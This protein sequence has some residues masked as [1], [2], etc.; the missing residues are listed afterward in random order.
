MKIE[1]LPRKDSK[2]DTS[3]IGGKIKQA[4][5][6]CGLSQIELAREIGLKSATAISLMESDM[7]GVDVQTLRKIAHITN[8]PITFF[9]SE[10]N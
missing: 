6:E 5:S 8:L 7:R 2:P 10:L 4:R 1:R 9:F 3:G